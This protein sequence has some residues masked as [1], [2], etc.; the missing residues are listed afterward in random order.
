LMLQAKALRSR[1]LL[2]RI[3]LLRPVLLT[4][5]SKENSTLLAKAEPGLQKDLAIGVCTLCVKTAHLL[6]DTIHAHLNTEYRSSGWHT[7][8]FAFAAA[9]ILLA[10]QLSPL[11][12][13]SLSS[14]HS[15]ESS[16]MSCIKILEHHQ[17][18]IHSAERAITILRALKEK[19]QATSPSEPVTTNQSNQNPPASSITG[20]PTFGDPSTASEFSNPPATPTIPQEYPA[21]TNGTIPDNVF[22]G[23]GIGIEQISMFDTNMQMDSINDAWFTQQLS[24]L[25]W[26]DYYQVAQ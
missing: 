4:S 1:F 19:V 23:T 17:V 3:L 24:D 10:A 11:I 14:E 2:V 5:V 22:T 21:V 8:Y 15:F 13:A 25:N 20:T 26:L 9:T 7:V 12:Q 18:Q 6:V 16:W